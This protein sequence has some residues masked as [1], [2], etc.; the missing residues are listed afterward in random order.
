MILIVSDPDVSYI[1]LIHIMI[2]SVKLRHV[3]LADY[4]LSDKKR[5]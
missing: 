3:Y 5:W 4:K 2:Y 1:S